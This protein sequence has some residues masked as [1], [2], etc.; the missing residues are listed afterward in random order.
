MISIHDEEGKIH[1][2]AFP[3]GKEGE[4]WRNLSSTLRFLGSRDVSAKHRNSDQQ[5]VKAQN[6]G[7]NT[8]STRLKEF[9]RRRKVLER[10]C[11]A[12]W[13][14]DVGDEGASLAELKVRRKRVRNLG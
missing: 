6:L 10:N 8:F 12:G 5:E 1:V 4:G 7:V 11:L 3:R 2:V 14:R 13:V 9:E